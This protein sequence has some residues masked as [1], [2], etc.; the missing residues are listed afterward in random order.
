MSDAH[1]ASAARRPRDVGRELPRRT[2]RREGHHRRGWS[3]PP[4]APSRPTPPRAGGRTAWSW[5]T[6]PGGAATSSTTAAVRPRSPATASPRR[7]PGT[8]TVLYAVADGRHTDLAAS[9]LQFRP[10]RLVTQFR[11]SPVLPPYA[12]A[13]PEAVW[14]AAGL[15]R[16]R[17]PDIRAPAHTLVAAPAGGTVRAV[18]RREPVTAWLARNAAGQDG[19]YEQIDGGRP[20]TLYRETR[21]GVRLTSLAPLDGG[22]VAVVALRSST[23]SRTASVLLV[24]PRQPDPQL[25]VTSA[26][27]PSALA[28]D[29]GVS[30]FGQRLAFR[31]RVGSARG[32][33]DQIVVLDVL[34]GTSRVVTSARLRTTRLSDPSLGFGRVVWSAA[35]VAGNAARALARAR[36][37]G[38]SDARE[39]V[40]ARLSRGG[41]RPDR[42]RVARGRRRRA[43]RRVR[44]LRARRTRLARLPGADEAQCQHVRPGRPPLRLP[45]LRHPL[46]AQHRLRGAARARGRPSS[47]ARSSRPPAST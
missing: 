28:Y 19:V 47:S 29:P 11:A 37:A 18:V 27:S 39:L 5:P 36:N 3:S 21:P 31:R 43:R 6:A 22:R 35:Q 33:T 13:G 26:P 24:T 45:Q 23:T 32:L 8:D 17:P 16:A 40:R 10:A 7:S 41:A 9:T 42:L 34:R 46:D 12:L 44:G 2:R 4:R 1:R 14:Y 20:A 25:L 30:A 38:V 15:V